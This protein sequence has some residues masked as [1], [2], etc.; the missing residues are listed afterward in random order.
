MKQEQIDE[1]KRK[2]D[3]DLKK[4]QNIQR[5]AADTVHANVNLPTIKSKQLEKQ[6]SKKPESTKTQD[7]GANSVVS[8]NQSGGITAG[9]INMEKQPR[10]LDNRLVEKIH[11]SLPKSAKINIYSN[12]T[13]PESINFA[14]Q[15]S[16][17]M[18][19]DGYRIGDEFRGIPVNAVYGIR[20]HKP[21]DSIYE[22]E[23]GIRE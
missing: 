12:A 22:I 4:F 11:L 9:T 6:I 2:C 19:R 18:K 8:M 14:D 17:W 7:F 3:D 23:V 5:S 21:N 10:Q 15:I 13:D 20:F 16:A 1:A